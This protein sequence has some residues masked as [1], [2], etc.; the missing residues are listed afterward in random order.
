MNNYTNVINLPEIINVTYVCDSL[1]DCALCPSSSS[2]ALE[3]L[4]THGAAQPAL[5]INRKIGF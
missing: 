2:A 1:Q 4:F 5:S 3:Q